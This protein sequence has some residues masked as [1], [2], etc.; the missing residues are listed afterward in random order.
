MLIAAGF[1]ADC[2]LLRDASQPNWRRGLKQTSA[3]VCDTLTAQ[4]LDGTCHIL[5]FPL[6]A[7]SSLQDLRTYEEFVRNPL[8][9]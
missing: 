1:D 5:T 8:G 9:S 3:V 2:L 7:E 4:S 6:V